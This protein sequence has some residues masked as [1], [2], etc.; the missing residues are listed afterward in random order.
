MNSTVARNSHFRNIKTFDF[1]FLIRPI[2]HE[3]HQST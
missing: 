1:C 2:S 3:E